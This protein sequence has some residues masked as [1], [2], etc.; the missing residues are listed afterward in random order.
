M[1]HLEH[2]AGLSLVISACMGQLYFLASCANTVTERMVKAAINSSLNF[3]IVLIL[4]VMNE[5]R[6]VWGPRNAQSPAN[7]CPA[8][9]K[10]TILNTENAVTQINR[11]AAFRRRVTGGVF[12]RYRRKA[13]DRYLKYRNR[14]SSS[15]QLH[16][17]VNRLGRFL[18][19][20]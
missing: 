14:H 9:Q 18:V 20:G 7:V 3:F 5:Y 2:L 16:G 17:L 4:W 12:F 19:D 10:D 6:N 15:Y 1:P 8:A 13:D 11:Y